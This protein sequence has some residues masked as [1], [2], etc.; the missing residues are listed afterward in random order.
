MSRRLWV[1]GLPVAVFLTFLPA[2]RFALVYD[3]HE[4]LVINPRLTSWSY[5]PGYFMTHLWAHLP[6]PGHYYRPVFL[7]WFRVI[8]ALLGAPAPIWHLASIVAH[9]AAAAAVFLMI[10]RMVNDLDSALLAAALFALYPLNAEVVAWVSS[11]GDLLLTLFLVLCVYFY[12]GRRQAIS[13]ASILFA[14][15]AMFTKES[16]IVAP[17]LI[18]T[19]E[20]TRSRL[21]DA[22]VNTVPYALPLILYMAFR[23]HALGTPAVVAVRSMSMATMLMTWP[24][25]L[26]FYA[27]HLLW[28]MHLSPC[29]DISLESSPLP[30]LLLIALTAGALWGLRRANA[31]V[32]FGAAWFVITLIPSLAIR[33]TDWNDYVHDRYL[34]LPLVGLALIAAEGIKRIR[35]NISRAVVAAAVLLL[36]CLGIRM[37]IE[38]WRDNIA[39]FRRAVEVAPGNHYVRNNLA[40]A[41][42]KAHR[43]PEAYPLLRQ[44][45]ELFPDLPDGY[46]NMAYYYQQ[47]GDLPEA[48][49]YY[50][51]SVSV[52]QRASPR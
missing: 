22:A 30:L 37:N 47:V 24:R 31:N 3:D 34:Y 29:Y 46:E 8:D 48:E 42:I 43:E 40:L 17:A 15:L 4:Q 38:V 21:K 19:Y 13:P 52:S 27:W 20:W 2:L 16:G 32:R 44:S 18:F 5:V 28:P 11:G 9:L 51:M 35:F 36:L 7:L 49:R 1:W 6:E 26:A 10:R 12:V 14:A 33:Y 25:L 50:R 41:Y 39:L 23:V 45:I